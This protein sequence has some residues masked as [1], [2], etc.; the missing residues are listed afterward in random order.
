[1]EKDARKLKRETE[2]ESQLP[3][4]DYED[5]DYVVDSQPPPSQEP[6]LYSQ[7]LYNN[8][9]SDIRAVNKKNVKDKTYWC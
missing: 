1:M 8:N 4:T 6:R 5:D 7:S 3:D 9:H 2:F